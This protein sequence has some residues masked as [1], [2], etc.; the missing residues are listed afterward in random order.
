MP[1]QRQQVSPT[2]LNV[3]AQRGHSLLDVLAYRLGAVLDE[4][5]LQQSLAVAD[6]GQPALHN[7]GPAQQETGVATVAVPCVCPKQNQY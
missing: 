4:G 6:L 7:L 5:L 1:R 2:Y 3:L